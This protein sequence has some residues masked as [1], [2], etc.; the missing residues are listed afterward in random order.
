[1][2]FERQS[3]TMNI[4]K[5]EDKLSFSKVVLLNF[6]IILI[7]MNICK[8]DANGMDYTFMDKAMHNQRIC[9]Y[10]QFYIN[11]GFLIWFVKNKD[12]YNWQL[13]LVSI[14]LLWITHFIVFVF[15]FVTVN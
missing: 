12:T 3:K 15:M 2:H 10:I 9:F 13:M 8:S 1:M 14:I 6:F 7:Y 11:I 4:L 5:N